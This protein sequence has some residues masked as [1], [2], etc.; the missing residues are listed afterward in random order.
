MEQFSESWW[1]VVFMTILLSGLCGGMA[2][3]AQLRGMASHR[4]NW[5]SS[6]VMGIAAAFL[7]PMFLNTIS[8]SLITESRDQPDKL[9]VLIGSASRQRT[10]PSNS[11]TRLDDGH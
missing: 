6:A 9:F 7:V 2:R 10:S 3:F 8:S 1:W 11:W 4:A 5:I